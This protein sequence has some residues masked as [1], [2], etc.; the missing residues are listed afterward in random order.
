MGIPCIVSVSGL[1]RT[2]KSGDEIL[3][4]GSTGNIKIIENE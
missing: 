4:D 1:L 2:L 3:M